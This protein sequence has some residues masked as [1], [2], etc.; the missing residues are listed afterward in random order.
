MTRRPDIAAL[1]L[2]ALSAVVLGLEVFQSRLVAYACSNVMIYAVIGI[3]MLG[4]GAAG[5]LVALR[6]GW[7]APERAPRVLAWSALAFS[8]AIVVAH[9]VFV[10]LTPQLADVDVLALAIAAVLGLP[11]VAAGIVVTLALTSGA[12]V[13]TIYAANLIGSGVGCFVPLVLLG[14]VD[15]EHLL[16]L[17]ALAAWLCAVPFVMRVP[18]RDLAL[19]VATGGSLLLALVSVGLAPRVFPI[20]P[21]PPPLGQ[22]ANLYEYG[23][24]RG[25]SIRTEFDRWNPTGRIEIVSLANVPGGPE[26]YPAMFY[27]QDSSAGSS[28]IAWD[29]RTKSS[30]RPTAEDPG[31]FVAR[32][33]TETLYGQGHV[34]PRGRVLVIGL[35]GGPDLQCA[36][37][38]E[39]ASIDVV[40]INRDSIAAIRGPLN[41]WVGEI[42]SDPRVRFHERDG[43]SFVHGRRGVYDLIQLSGVDTKNNLASGALAMSENH[44]YT[45]EAFR[46]YVGALSEDGAISIIRFGEPEALRLANTAAIVLRE[47]GVEHPEQHI[48][49]ASVGLAYG[50]VIRRKP[51]TLALGRALEQQLLPPYFRGIDICYYRDHGLPFHQPSIV[52]YVPGA[53]RGNVFDAFFAAMAQG[54]LSEAAALYPFD[55]APTSDDRPFFFDIFR[56][57]NAVTWQM[58][59]VVGLRNL[60]LSVIG[61]SLALILAPVRRLRGQR[62]RGAAGPGTPL[63]FASVGLGFILL[64]VW[65]LHRFTTYLGHQVYALSVVLATLL[66][67]T[68]VGAAAGDR[69]RVDASRRA[70]IGAAAVAIAAIGA[71]LGAPAVLEAT[72]DAGLPWRVAIAVAFIAPLGLV[73]GQPFVAGLASLRAREPAR[74]PWC[75]G[76]NSFFSVIGSVAVIP[77]L[78]AVGYVGSLLGAIA[79]YGVATALA[80]SMR[81]PAEPSATP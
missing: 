66:I 36:L 48:T 38:H 75:V 14:P 33:C 30:V 17:L 63:Y 32:M 19:R 12:R 77:L 42:G 39:A 9:A 49:V 54:S 43:R 58:P 65:L 28:L 4:F 69:L 55:I 64:E 21:D 71:A 15:G 50:V 34:E 40:E 7:R 1:P 61:L 10:R 22:L 81:P 11:F 47:F 23:A 73:L 74:V 31:S 60:L 2:F 52:Q 72:W 53:P 26:P 29:G 79:C 27:A 51:W 35:G 46:D 3:A 5:S 67:A 76:I 68:G 45:L 78:L 44:L 80:A 57:D 16:G 25:I 13:G 37:Y 8:V 18:G 56:Y 20:Q 6:P 41:D 70:Q 59:H 62:G 24:A